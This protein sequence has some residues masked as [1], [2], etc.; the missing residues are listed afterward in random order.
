MSEKVVIQ[1]KKYGKN[2]Y[3]ALTISRIHFVS[4]VLTVLIILDCVHTVFI[5]LRYFFQ[6]IG[7]LKIEYM[8]YIMTSRQGIHQFSFL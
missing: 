4:I 3:N 8:H 1:S 2:I 7:L 6:G 5:D